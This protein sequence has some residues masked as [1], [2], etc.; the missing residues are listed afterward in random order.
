MT[1]RI[2]NESDRFDIAAEWV[3]YSSSLR[4]SSGAAKLTNLIGRSKRLPDDRE[5]WN[6]WQERVIPSGSG[7]YL[8]VFREE[9]Q[10]D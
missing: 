9:S 6:V 10:T 4:R 2:P 5:G 3:A 8:A 1:G 7:R